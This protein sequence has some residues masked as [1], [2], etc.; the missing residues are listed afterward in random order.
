MFQ[1]RLHT[2]ARN[3]RFL[4]SEKNGLSIK[5]SRQPIEIQQAFMRAHRSAELRAEL[6]VSLLVSFFVGPSRARFGPT[7]HR[8]NAI[9]Q[10]RGGATGARAE[11]D[12]STRTGATMWTGRSAAPAMETL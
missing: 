10:R 7:A 3:A 9:E 2:G 8:R 12:R 11:T 5:A 1:A 4:W 6:P